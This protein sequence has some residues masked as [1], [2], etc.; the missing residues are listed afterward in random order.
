MMDLPQHIYRMET[1]FDKA[2]YLL[3]SL[4]EK[5]SE[6]EAFQLEIQKLEEYYE[7]PLWKKDFEMDEA[8]MFPEEVKRGVLSEDGIYNILERYKELLDLLKGPDKTE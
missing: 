4:E 2:Q 1:I 5:I 6:F 8:G 7:S 3:N